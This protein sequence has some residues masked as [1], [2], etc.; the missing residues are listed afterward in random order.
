MKKS[1]ITYIF[2]PLINILIFCGSC[3]SDSLPEP[4]PAQPEPSIEYP[5]SYQ[6]KIRTR[7]YPKADNELFLNP[8]PLIVPQT[9]KKG[10]RLQFSLSSSKSFDS[11]DTFVSEPQEWCLYN[12]HRPLDAG[13]WYWRFRSTSADGNTPGAWSDTYSFEV[14]DGTPIFVTPEFKT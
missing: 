12:L 10:E 1:S 7:P 3:S 8:A 2:L 5:D 9:M 6:D 13:T 4:E 14:K 11:S